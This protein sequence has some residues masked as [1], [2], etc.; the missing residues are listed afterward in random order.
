MHPN[1]IADT[2]SPDLPR[3]LYCI[4]IGF[5]CYK[6]TEGGTRVI[7]LIKQLVA[8]FKADDMKLQQVLQFIFWSI[9]K[10]CTSCNPPFIDQDTGYSP[11]LA[12]LEKLNVCLYNF[13]FSRS[14]FIQLAFLLCRRMLDPTGRLHVFYRILLNVYLAFSLCSPW[15][16]VAPCNNVNPVSLCNHKLHFPEPQLQHLPSFFQAQPSIGQ[17]IPDHPLED[18]AVLLIQPRLVEPV[19]A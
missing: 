9:S 4:V 3:V 12:F 17:H 10:E 16:G 19:K 14:Q 13:H 7:A 2:F 6:G 1:P 15:V 11:M 18:L 8:K 5:L